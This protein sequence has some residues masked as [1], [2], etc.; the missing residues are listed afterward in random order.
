MLKQLI[1]NRLIRRRLL[2]RDT[3]YGLTHAP[4]LGAVRSRVASLFCAGRENEKLAAFKAFWA[5]DAALLG[6][7]GAR[8][9]AHAMDSAGVQCFAVFVEFESDVSCAPKV[10]MTLKDMI[11]LLMWCGI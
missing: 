5:S 11:V 2:Q 10:S 9:W 1:S 8:G 4:G 3:N 7:P 6:E